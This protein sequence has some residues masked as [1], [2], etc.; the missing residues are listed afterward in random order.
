VSVR[1]DAASP[2]DD[3][4][5]EAVPFWRTRSP[6]EMTA[7]EWESLCDGCGKCCLHKLQDA[8]AADGT[9]G[10]VW[11]TA[12]ACRLLDLGSCRCGA[13]ADRFRHVPDCVRLD[14]ETVATS[15]W[16]PPTC[17]YRL[18]HEGRDLMWWHPLVS[19][20]PETVHLAG[21]SVRGRA[22]SERKAGPP[23]HHIVTWTDV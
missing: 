15:P 13:Y 12:V 20:D 7:T 14:P 22:V 4:P 3:P 17:A 8:D 9:P 11:T 21:V 2:G 10:R 1:D 5:G 18:V 6:A 16:L 19:G 23:E